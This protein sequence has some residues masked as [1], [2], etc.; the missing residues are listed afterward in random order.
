MTDVEWDRLE[1]IATSDDARR[2]I[3]R[4]APLVTVRMWRS[5]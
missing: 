4:I 3:H 2:V 5:G 1:P